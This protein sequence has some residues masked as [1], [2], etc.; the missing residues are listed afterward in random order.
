VLCAAHLWYAPR[1]PDHYDGVTAMYHWLARRTIRRKSDA[2][3]DLLRSRVSLTTHRT[4]KSNF[5]RSAH[6]VPNLESEA[7]YAGAV[8]Q[9]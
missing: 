8:E 5:A 6:S 1:I 7:S 3:M 4:R 2:F 9:Q